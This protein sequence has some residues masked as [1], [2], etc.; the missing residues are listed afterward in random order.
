M[1]SPTVVAAASLAIPPFTSS[2]LTVT[3]PTGTAEHDILIGFAIVYFGNL[4]VNFP[5]G[6]TMLPSLTAPSEGATLFVGW[7]RAGASEPADYTFTLSGSGTVYDLQAALVSVRGARRTGTPIDV[8]GS[9]GVA[10]NSTTAVDAP[11]VTPTLTDGLLLTAHY[12][13]PQ[14]S[15]FG[16]E[17]DSVSFTGAPSGMTQVHLTDG[18]WDMQI[19][20]Q[21]LSST[22]AT[23]VK[24]ATRTNT[25]IKEELGYSLVIFQQST[26]PSISPVTEDDLSLTDT[27]PDIQVQITDADAAETLTTTVELSTSETFTSV[28]QTLQTTESSPASSVTETLT[29][30]AL[31]YGVR[32]YWRAKV[33]DGTNTSD[34]TETRSF[35]IYQAP[36]VTITAPADGGTV[37]TGGPVLSVAWTYDQG[38][39]LEQATWRVRVQNDAGSTTYYDSGTRSGTDASL[40]IDCIAEG[41]PT[42]TTDIKVVV[43]VTCE[44]TGQSATD[45]NS[46]ELLWGVVTLTIDTPVDGSVV[47]DSQVTVE[48]TFASTRSKT[49]G[50]WRVRL[51]YAGGTVVLYDTGWQDGTDSSFLIPFVLSTGSGYR[52]EVDVENSE[53]IRAS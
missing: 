43:D 50:R 25:R 51:L 14:Y 4:T 20:K 33:G 15:L 52:V 38:E 11:S 6:F 22:A 26:T 31:S 24:S 49:Q 16:G 36:T 41:V 5:S 18:I 37:S 27:T 29:P 7:K 47:A 39:D 42:D 32:Y 48:W 19:N 53:G 3:K 28:A 1:A 40:D 46:F 34:W 35:I 8:Y 23:G 30:T 2:P 12:R 45:T 17:T 10:A 44:T 9:L 13:T 21:A